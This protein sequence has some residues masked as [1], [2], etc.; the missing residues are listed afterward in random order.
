MSRISLVLNNNAW[1]LKA[2][3]AYELRDHMFN[4]MNTLRRRDG[5]E[6][7]KDH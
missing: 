1:Q 2:W 6:T 5:E 7:E 4:I 3:R